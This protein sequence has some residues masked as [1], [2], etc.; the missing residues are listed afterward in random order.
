[1][2]YEESILRDPYSLAHW[3]NY[4]E[5]KADTSAQNATAPTDNTP[6]APTPTPST[7]TQTRAQRWIIF[8]RAVRVLPG[9][10]K[11]WMKYLKERMVCWSAVTPRW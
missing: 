3:L 5:F 2:A 7:S 9:S 8:E 11:L 6:H 1:M 10:Y 4:L